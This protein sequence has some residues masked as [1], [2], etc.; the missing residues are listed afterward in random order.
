VK[1]TYRQANLAISKDHEKV[2]KCG[3][4]LPLIMTEEEVEAEGRIIIAEM[5]QLLTATYCKPESVH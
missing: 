2:K 4:A 1:N 5:E 3:T